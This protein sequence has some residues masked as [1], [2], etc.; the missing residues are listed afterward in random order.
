MFSKTWTSKS[1]GN[2]SQKIE[3]LKA[4]IQGA[5]AILIGAGSGLSTSAGLTYGGERF[6]KYFSDFHE[7][8]GI[9]D[10]YSG[11]LSVSLFGGILGL[12]EPTY[13]LQ[14]LRCDTRQALC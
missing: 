3:Q 2:Y 12:V 10:M 7:K 4:E 14:S 13:L 6:L 5:D 1:T 9:T 11:G 8:Y